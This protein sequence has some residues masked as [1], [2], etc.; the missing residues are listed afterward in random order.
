ML[1]LLVLLSASLTGELSL[2]F[3][4]AFIAVYIAYVIYV[5]VQDKI[6]DSQKKR[7]QSMRNT[8]LS[9][10]N[11]EE[12]ISAGT[13]DFHKDEALDEDAYFIYDAKNRIVDIQIHKVED[14][15]T[16]NDVF[17][18]KKSFAA[19]K[20]LHRSN[21]DSIVT[22]DSKRI[23]SL[24]N[25]LK[26]KPTIQQPQ[27]FESNTTNNEIL[28]NSPRSPK[29]VLSLSDKLKKVKIDKSEN[30][31]ALIDHNYIDDEEENGHD[32]EE[33][34]LSNPKSAMN[35][36]V[37][38][39]K[40]KVVW[41]MLKLKRIFIQGIEGEKPF[42]ELNIIDK[43]L[44]IFIDA[45][46]DF[47]RRLTIPPGSEE[48]WNRRFAVISPIFCI[49]WVFYATG[50]WDFASAPPISFYICEAI[51]I[52][53]SFIIFFR[54]PLTRPPRR[55][56]IVFSIVCFLISILWIFFIANV[57]VDLMNLLGLI[58]GLNP[59]FLGITI[60]AAG[61]SMADLK[62][63]AAVAKQGLARMALT[64]CFA[65]PMFNL[66]VGLGVSIIMSVAAEGKATPFEFKDRDG[67]LPLMGVGA[68]F[69]QLFLILILSCI[70]KFY[71]KK[72]Q[73][74]IQAFYYLAAISLITV[75]S[76]TFAK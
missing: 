56:L 43:I 30:L 3:G 66:L 73:A 69:I 13:E 16:Y 37:K 35:Q 63:N 70:F 48:Q 18:I 5:V 29:L 74:V 65:G 24:D 45:P 12:S 31:H 58:I 23:E 40:V 67:L 2:P 71:L 76:F 10:K 1:A 11:F 26:K 15:N 50:I 68:L 8:M 28:E 46:F 75:A 61:L 25:T 21:T 33:Q 42:K 6:D 27:S 17:L 9:G 54:T 60:L 62:V 38:E 49:L 41:S 52:I 14:D 57:L 47:L 19:R 64:G 51:A 72:P 22:D 39:Y 59:A 34:M 53:L 55:S 36:T 4:I 44:F 7:R 20:S 32:Q